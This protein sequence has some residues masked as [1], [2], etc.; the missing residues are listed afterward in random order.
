MLKILQIKNNLMKIILL[1]KNHLNL[2]KNIF[3][4]NLKSLQTNKMFDYLKN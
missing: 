2:L 4:I 1:K 3:S